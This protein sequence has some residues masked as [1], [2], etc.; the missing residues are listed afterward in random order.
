MLDEITYITVGLG[1]IGWLWV[2]WDVIKR[3]KL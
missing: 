2:F 3:E 1:L